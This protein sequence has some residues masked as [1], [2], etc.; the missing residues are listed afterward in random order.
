M[1]YRA[2]LF[3]PDEK[4]ARTVTQVLTELDFSVETSA[5]PFAA[6]KKL[7][8]EH[9]DAL[10]VDS[11][12]QQNATL[13]FKTARN[14]G[15]NQNSLSVAIVEGQSGVAKAFQIG[16]NLVLTKPI[17]V[18]QSK[19]TIRVARG[20]LRKTEAAKGPAATPASDQNFGTSFNNRDSRTP[21][22]D[23]PVTTMPPSLISP[24]SGPVIASPTALFDV[25]KEPIP[26]PEPMEAAVL[27]SM[28]EPI[29]SKPPASPIGGPSVS[30]TSSWQPVSQPMAQPMATALQHADQALGKTKSESPVGH[31]IFSHAGS[32]TAA[33]AAPAREVSKVEEEIEAFEATELSKTPIAAA[34]PSGS[35]TGLIAVFVVVAVA[36][37]GYYGWTKMHLGASF[38]KASK[39]APVAQALAPAVTTQ[40][41]PS[42]S[43]PEPYSAVVTATP[44]PRTAPVTTPDAPPAAAKKAVTSISVGDVSKSVASVP[45]SEVLVVNNGPAKPASS[46]PTTQS[47]T[48]P[49]PAPSIVSSGSEASAVSGLM[50]MP[51]STP[52]PA[53]HTLRISQGVSQGLLV[54]KV[55]PV[56]P[57]RALAM[58]IQGAVELLATINKDGNVSEVKLLSGD[59]M[60]AR[61][62]MDAVKQWKYKPYY[63]DDKPLEIQTQITVNFK[64]P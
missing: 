44:L 52:Q 54:K 4:T 9:F 39:P 12:N 34:S 51:A 53:A 55:A 21:I 6:V 18:E 29:V 47:D 45:R 48:E 56:Y 61:A 16:A 37:A 24:P 27:E 15:S 30:K 62:A 42:T 8:S 13:L 64:A 14:S 59:T 36:A 58:S 5:E 63:L 25:E 23:R 26:T 19:G 40:T 22:S 33:A 10:V 11:D 28:P 20:L 31:A 7:T 3:C 32:G 46:P 17:N 50:E 43:S 57:Q 2:L 35:R 38:V 41:A 60:L 49:A 1:S